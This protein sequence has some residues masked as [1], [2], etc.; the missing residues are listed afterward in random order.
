MMIDD[1]AAGSSGLEIGQELCGRRIIADPHIGR[2]Q[3]GGDGFADRFDIVH[4]PHKGA[5]DRHGDPLNRSRMGDGVP[6][7]DT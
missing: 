4:Q 5:I 2:F 7:R 1:Q 6:S 3:H